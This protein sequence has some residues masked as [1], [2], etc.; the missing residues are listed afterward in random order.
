MI[1]PIQLADKG[2][3]LT[4]ELPLKGMRRLVEACW[5]E[6]GLVSVDLHFARETSDDLRVM[7]GRITAQVRF[8]CQRCMGELAVELLTEPRLLLLR[9]GERED[10]IE[11]DDVLIIEQSITLGQLV[12]DE[13]L[14]EVPMVPMHP[15]AQCPAQPLITE[16]Q[17]E[18]KEAAGTNPFAVLEQLKR[19]DR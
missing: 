3:R 2:A 17:A 6:Q 11:D 13:L 1:D 10:L 12:E 5:D 18:K 8:T 7:R 9:P 15:V 19:R 16:P 4:G 14:L